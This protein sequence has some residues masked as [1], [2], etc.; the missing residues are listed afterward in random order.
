MPLTMRLASAVTIATAAAL[1]FSAT[2]AAAE[3]V[4]CGQVITEDTTL[5]NDLNCGVAAIVIGAS[6]ITLDLNGHSVSAG[7]YAIV[8][9]GHDDVTIRNGSVAADV[10]SLRVVGG[11]R[12]RLEDLVVGGFIVGI[13]LEDSDGARV[14]S[15]E[16]RD[17]GV[18]ARDGDRTTIS[19]NSL[20][21]REAFISVA[22]SNHNRIV[23][24][25]VT[26]TD[27]CPICL[28]SSD[29]SRI[30][31]NTV[32]SDFE[33]IALGASNDNVIVDNVGRAED[34]VIQ[35]F[36]SRGLELHASSRN[37]VARNAF[38]GKRIGVWMESGADNE[39][40]RNEALS[41]RT[42]DLFPS[43]EP[44]GFRVEAGASGTLLHANTASANPDDGFDVEAAGTRLRRNVANGNGDLGIEAVP[45]VIDLG[46]NRASGNG[47]PLQC[48]NVVCR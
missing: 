18:S 20:R 25:D 24:N 48:L 46:G 5:E 37:V 28:G 47:N 42:S 12:N 7:D 19:E 4:T 40:R 1:A 41:G 29:H 36:Q 8:N 6:G 43:F 34:P 21:G 33:G 11:D 30:A 2:P 31:R 9:E 35:W 32:V 3:P 22:G 14:A 16:F 10:S 45:G 23:E 17:V 26:G 27:G 39:F 44:D 15:N 13:E 38:T